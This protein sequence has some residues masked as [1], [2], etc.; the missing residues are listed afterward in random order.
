MEK[1]KIIMIII[2][3]I[4][5]LILLL[6]GTGLISLK[7]KETF[8]PAFQD[9]EREVFENTKS[10]VHGKIQDLSNYYAEYQ[11]ASE[12]DRHIIQNVIHMQF[13]NF[14]AEDID[15]EMLRAF[16]IKTRGF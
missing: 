12:E 5:L 10:Y 14:D 3:S 9:V 1:L 16:L 7:F 15:N 13:S 6:F 4:A 2:G 8:S 11:K